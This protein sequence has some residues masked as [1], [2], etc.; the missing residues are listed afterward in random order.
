MPS[1]FSPRSGR[2]RTSQRVAIVVATLSL[3]GCTID[4]PQPTAPVEPTVEVLPEP[5][6]APPVAPPAEP[7][8]S[9]V[10]PQDLSATLNAAVA[11]AIQAYGGRAAVAVS[12][13]AGE[14]AA[15]D[16]TGFASWS[17]IKVPIAIAALKEHPEMASQAAAAIQVSDNDAAMA[18]WNSVAP[19]SVEAVLAE[20][21]SPVAVQRVRV[22]PEFSPFGQTQWTVTEQARFASNLNCISGAAPVVQLM[23][24]ISPDQ[25][26][27]LG[28][29]P[30][31]RFKGGWGPSATTGGYEVRQF[32]LV[33]DSSGR[34]IAVAIAVSSGDGSYARGQTMA[35]QLVGAIIPALTSAPAA[36]C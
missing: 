35:S 11:S 12:G 2:V 33:P 3:T 7:D 28:T 9:D 23:G 1:T 18:L 30:G 14:F 26:Y 34:Q 4:G 25:S 13:P 31:A 20:G 17:T 27:G 19:E 21:G 15:G 32:G 8:H 6:L 36:A 10:P 5:T 22:R 24:G 29:I 16:A